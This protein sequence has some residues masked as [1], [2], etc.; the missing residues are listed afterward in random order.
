MGN[1]SQF[2]GAMVPGDPSWKFGLWG[3]GN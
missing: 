1:A 2:H 3:P